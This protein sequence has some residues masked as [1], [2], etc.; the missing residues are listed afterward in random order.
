LQHRDE[1]SDKIP[2]QMLNG[3]LP[4]EDKRYKCRKNWFYGVRNVIEH[5]IKVEAITEIPDIVQEFSDYIN[6]EE[7][8]QKERTTPED[9]QL[10]NQVIN[11]MLENF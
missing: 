8:A 11:F 6:S 4:S 3:S 2:E 5:L 10:G 9:I 1:W 7:F